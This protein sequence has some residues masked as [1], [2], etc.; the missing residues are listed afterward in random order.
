MGHPSDDIGPLRPTQN[1]LEL[2]GELLKAHGVSVVD[3]A[4]GR[5]RRHVNGGSDGGLLLLLG[6]GCVV[7]IGI[8]IVA[9]DTVQ[10]GNVGVVLVLVGQGGLFGAVVAC[11][12]RRGGGRHIRG[13]STGSKVRS[14]RRFDAIV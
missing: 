14:S 2:G 1:A 11:V 4:S 9:L 13:I 7:G 8:G 5:I 3:G 10:F 12:V 6:I